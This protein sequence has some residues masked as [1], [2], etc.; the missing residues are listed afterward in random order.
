MDCRPLGEAMAHLRCCKRVLRTKAL[1]VAQS[2]WGD[3]HINRYSP[4]QT[5]VRTDVPTIPGGWLPGSPF[6]GVSTTVNRASGPQQSVESS[7]PTAPRGKRADLLQQGAPPPPLSPVA[8]LTTR[9][10][11][12]RGWRPEPGDQRQ[13]VGEHL[14]RHRDLG[15]L[16]SD[17][18]TVAEDLGADLDQLLAQAGQRPRLRCFRQRQRSHEIAQ[19]VRK[20]VELEADDVGGE[21]TA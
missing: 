18:A 9:L 13:D 6:R 11:C 1:P 2:A 3:V 20:D 21:G 4:D 15:Q 10:S 16:E 17:V 7:R 8:N 14:S 5:W 12:R 19:V